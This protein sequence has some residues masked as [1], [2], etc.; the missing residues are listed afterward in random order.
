MRYRGQGAARRRAGRLAVAAV[1]CATCV[2]AA[3]RSSATAPVEFRYDAPWASGGGRET[4]PPDRRDAAAK[5][6]FPSDALCRWLPARRSGAGPHAA[7][8]GRA[9]AA[10]AQALRENIARIESFFSG[11]PRFAAPL[12]ICMQFSN[13]G[14]RGGIEG[15]HALRGDFLIGAWP[16]EWLYRRNGRL[17]FDGETRH[18]VGAV[19]TMP[20]DPSNSIEDAQGPITRADSRVLRPV[21]M[22]QGLPVHDGGLLVIARNDRPL[23]RPAPFE[24]LA[25]W[26]L[27]ELD[28]RQFESRTGTSPREREAAEKATAVRRE[29]TAALARMSAAERAASG[30]FVRDEVEFGS[31]ISLVVPEADARCATRMVEPN[32]DY[33]DRSLPP[34]AIQLVTLR[35]LP[36][37]PPRGGLVGVPRARQKITW[38][39]QV[40]FWGADWQA[41][42]AST[43]P[44]R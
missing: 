4:D 34:S 38:M 22:H 11:N 17:V 30:C 39:N 1:L 18:I 2:A 28:H 6:E 20:T 37:E 25:R 32:P 44:V 43:L 9:S 35:S 33:F 41:F 8:A 40:I 14:W 31:R 15:G 21:G 3:A 13:G 10:D 16:G 29:L 12:G 27:A 5:Q 19:N 26:V 36:P 24:R 7:Q 23:F 42:R